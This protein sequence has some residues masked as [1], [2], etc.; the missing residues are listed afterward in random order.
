MR[1]DDKVVIASDGVRTEICVNGIVYGD[2]VTGIVFEHQAGKKRA[3]IT[4][5]TDTLPVVGKTEKEDFKR[6]VEKLMKE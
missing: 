5:C 3:D 1:P 4:I 6:W 2:N